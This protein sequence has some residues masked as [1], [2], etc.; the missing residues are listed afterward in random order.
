MADTLLSE[1]DKFLSETGMKEYRFGVPR[2]P[3]RQAR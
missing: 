1:I 2:S 3:Q